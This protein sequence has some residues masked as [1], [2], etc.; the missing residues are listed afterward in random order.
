[1]GQPIQAATLEAALQAVQQDVR[2]AANAPGGPQCGPK[3]GR[4]LAVRCSADKIEWITASLF[5]CRKLRHSK[6]ATGASRQHY[7]PSL[8][9]AWS[10]FGARWPPHSCSRACCG[11]ASSWSAMHPPTPRPSPIRIA[12]VGGGRKL[13]DGLCKPGVW[14]KEVVRVVRTRGVAASC[15]RGCKLGVWLLLG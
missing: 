11:P 4:R 1:M 3:G 6:C 5:A 12:L 9:V 15:G 13:C 7:C 8:Q 14:L 2:I 10:S